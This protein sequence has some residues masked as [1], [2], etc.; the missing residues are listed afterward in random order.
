M[1][2]QTRTRNL[3]PPLSGLYQ[4]LFP[5]I[6]PLLRFVAGAML[7]PHGCQKL[8]GMFGGGGLAGTAQ[9]MDRVGYHPG[10]LWAYVVGLNEVIAGALLAIGLL[11]RPA[12]AAV[13]IQMLFVIPVT[14][15]R[16]WFEG[17]E[18]AVLWLSVAIFFLIRGGGRYSVDRAIGWEF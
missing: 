5:W 9:F 8:F 13:T 14:I 4:A 7:V 15:R 3:I 12:A 2:D 16:G 1:A 17:N 18:L 10:T 6:E 11:T